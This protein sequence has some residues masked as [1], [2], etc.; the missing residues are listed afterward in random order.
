MSKEKPE[1]S[2]RQWASQ[3]LSKSQLLPFEVSY[4]LTEISAFSQALWTKTKPRALDLPLPPA[5]EAADLFWKP[6]M[7]PGEIIDVVLTL[8]RQK[9]QGSRHNDR[10]EPRR[11]EN[12][13]EKWG[14]TFRTFRRRRWDRWVNL[15]RNG[16]V[17][18]IRDV[19]NTES[20]TLP[21]SG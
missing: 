11:I 20:N 8:A 12:N 18:R 5:V 15:V 10:L 13:S 3:A 4:C 6:K 19:W 1:I 21:C 14:A 17:T 2:V 16:R 9:K 7:T